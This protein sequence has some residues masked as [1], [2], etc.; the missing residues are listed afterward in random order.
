MRRC[1]MKL[2]LRRT[3]ELTPS[4]ISD[5]GARISIPF[6]NYIEIISEGAVDGRSIYSRECA[7]PCARL[8]SDTLIYRH[9]HSQDIPFSRYNK[10]DVVL[11]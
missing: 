10:R 2:P 4:D 9:S 8:Q 6:E 3:R 7:T 5:H 11:V 1:V